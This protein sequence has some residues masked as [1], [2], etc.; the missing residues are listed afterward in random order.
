MRIACAPRKLSTRRSA[1][2][3]R[4][5][6]R[7][8]E[9]PPPRFPPGGGVLP[10]FL[11]PQL[12]PLPQPRVPPLA[13]LLPST[14]RT[15]LLRCPILPIDPL[16]EPGKGPRESPYLGGYLRSLSQR[17]PQNLVNRVP[18]RQ[19]SR[20]PCAWCSRSPRP[21]GSPAGSGYVGNPGP[22]QPGRLRI[23]APVLDFLPGKLIVFFLE[24]S[25]VPVSQRGLYTC[26]H[27]RLLFTALGLRPFFPSI[28]QILPSAHQMP[29][30]GWGTAGS[31]RTWRATG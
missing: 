30:A 18:S 27:W 2:A 19:L 28:Q 12:R 21:V 10:A 26:W 6:S 14:L 1:R 24:S 5:W 4:S 7:H 16:S 29:G 9:R 3:I 20:V 23:L 8:P 25:Q 31:Q 17:R 15:T 11:L 22:G 13:T